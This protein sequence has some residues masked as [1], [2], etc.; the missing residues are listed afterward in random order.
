MEDNARC[1]DSFP[2]DSQNP[3]STFLS[4]TMGTGA[5]TIRACIH[6]FQ[7]FLSFFRSQMRAGTSE[8]SLISILTCIVFLVLTRDKC[9]QVKGFNPVF[10]HAYQCC[11][12]SNYS[13]RHLNQPCLAHS[14]MG[15]SERAVPCE[16]CV[17]DSKCK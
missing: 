14:K 11:M 4:S 6:E 9:F 10:P 5:G 17:S 15:P 13:K 12:C 8:C 1:C 16:W 3:F 7:L 2:V